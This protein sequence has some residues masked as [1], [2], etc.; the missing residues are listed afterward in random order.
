MRGGG[1][2]IV[3]ATLV[4]A[5]AGPSRAQDMPP[6]A[7]LAPVTVPPAPAPATQAPVLVEPP[8][9]PKRM[10]LSQQ[11]W[12][13]ASLGG[14]A[15]GVIVVGILLTPADTYRGNADSGVVTVF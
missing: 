5:G 8:P 11:W 10:R 9:A 7:P 12:F 1:L 15:V 6:P 14:A 13:W 2:I 3:A 4:L